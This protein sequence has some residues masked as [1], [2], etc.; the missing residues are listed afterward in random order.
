[1]SASIV[2]LPTLWLGCTDEPA[3]S[4]PFYDDSGTDTDTDTD[5]TGGT[6]PTGEPGVAQPYN[7]RCKQDAPGAAITDATGVFRVTG[8]PDAPASFGVGTWVSGTGSLE[9]Y[10]C[11]PSAASEILDR[12]N[13]DLEL[14]LFDIDDQAID[15]PVDLDATSVNVLWGTVSDWDGIT[16]WTAGDGFMHFRRGLGSFSTL[17]KQ[18]RL[19][20]TIDVS[21]TEPAGHAM[22][23]E[24]DLTW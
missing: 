7:G 23:I 19:V 9:V 24:I 2:W 16:N 5:T 18:G 12:L 13:L 14:V 15:L 22:N 17:D 21:E 1:M 8:P 6:T 10:T 11:V 4:V 3:H 20:G